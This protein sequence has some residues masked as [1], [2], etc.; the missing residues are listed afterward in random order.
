MEK[1]KSV[2]LNVRGQSDA[3]WY[4]DGLQFTCSQCG[5][6][7]TGGP[8]HVWVSDEEL[9]RLAEYLKLSRQQVIEQFCRHVNGKYTLDER[10]T[11][12]GKYD[13][14]FLKE[15]KPATTGSPARKSCS[16]YSVRPLQCRTWP[17]WPSLLASKLAW[18]H[19]GQTCLGIN[20]GEKFS[21]RRI[22][23]IR[24]AQ[25]WP[26]H[27]PTSGGTSMRFDPDDAGG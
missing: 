10:R 25:D 22:E 8:G 24:D 20:H 9:D 13:C 15:T 21:L 14:I 7:C 12:E 11:A 5:N 19:A 4:A 18:D 27:P 3:P 2:R 16:I 23:S 1:K 6:C 26:P 17:F